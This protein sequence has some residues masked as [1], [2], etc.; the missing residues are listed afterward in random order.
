MKNQSNMQ[1]D[2]ALTFEK[3]K[4]FVNSEL[5]RNCNKRSGNYSSDV[6]QHKYIHSQHENPQ[7]I[8]FSSELETFVECLLE[9]ENSPEQIAGRAKFNGINCVS[10]KRLYQHIGGIKSME[11]FTTS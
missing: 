7:H 9:K 3:D 1:I 5:R 10:P 2:I 4:S 6:A 11:V 8:I